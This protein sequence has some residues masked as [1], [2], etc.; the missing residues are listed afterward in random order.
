MQAGELRDLEPWPRH[1]AA[2]SAG[3]ISFAYS[4]VPRGSKPSTYSAPTIAS[5]KLFKL[6]LIV[7]KNALPPGADAAAQAA[8]MR[9][10]IRH[11]LEHL[12]AR[13]GVE[14]AG[15][16]S[17]RAARRRR[18][19]SRW[20][21]R[22]SAACCAR[23]RD[24]LGRHVDGDDARAARGQTFGEQAAAAADVEHAQAGERR[25]RRDVVE[26][27]LVDV[28]QRAERAA[29]VPPFAR[30][31]TRISRARSN[32]RSP[33]VSSS[34]QLPSPNARPQRRSRRRRGAAPR[35]LRRAARRRPRRRSRRAVRQ[36][37][38]AATRDRATADA[39]RPTGRRR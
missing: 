26:A 12:E 23:R 29:R 38:P 30:R 33:S 1:H 28:V 34:A 3:R 15:H 6:R 4:C 13:H 27:Q 39:R 37:K 5:A 9:L 17:A 36:R 2:S 10:G 24:V 25:A 11:V 7:E 21:R 22:R 8:T 18:S 14:L 32:L 35:A 20:S 31:G 16:L 19:D